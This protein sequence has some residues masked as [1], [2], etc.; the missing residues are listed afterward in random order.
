VR[1]RFHVQAEREHLARVTYYE[2]ERAGLGARYLDDFDAA[3]EMVCAAPWRSR[4]VRD[5]DIRRAYLRAFPCSIVYREIRGEVQVLAVMHHRQRPG[6][7]L[8]RL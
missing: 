6:Y 5:P 4:L 7:W 8:A 1:H 3:I 2:G